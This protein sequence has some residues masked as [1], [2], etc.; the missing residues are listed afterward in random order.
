[1]RIKSPTASERCTAYVALLSALTFCLASL[2]P[3]PGSGS[4]R[5]ALRAR[6][7]ERERGSSDGARL[8]LAPRAERKPGRGNERPRMGAASPSSA[9]SSSAATLGARLLMERA[10]FLPSFMCDAAPLASTPSSSMS[11]T[12]RSAETKSTM[13]NELGSRAVTLAWPRQSS[14][15]YVTTST[16]A[17]R[18]HNARQHRR[19]TCSKIQHLYNFERNAHLT[20]RMQRGLCVDGCCPSRGDCAR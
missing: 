1:M 13:H 4:P 16:S 3:S 8:V 18:I 9:M 7:R 2:K 14:A 20:R 6:E 5:D 19:S 15:L 11:A 12:K 17:S 10:R